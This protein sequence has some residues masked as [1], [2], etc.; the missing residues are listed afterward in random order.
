MDLVKS[1]TIAAQLE[2]FSRLPRSRQIGLIVGVAAIVAAAVLVLL[3]SQEPTYDTLYANLDDKDAGEVVDA[4]KNQGIDYKLDDKDGAIMVPAAKVHETRIKMAVLGLPRGGSA[5]F[6]ILDKNTSGFGVSQFMEKARYTRALEGE[7]ARSIMTIDGIH[8]ARVHLAIPKQTVFIREREKPTASVVVTLL[9][10]VNLDKKQVDAIV[11][12][13]ASSIPK[14]VPDAVTVVDQSGNLLSS[15]EKSPEMEL[16]DRQFSYT[17]RLEKSYVDR[18]EHILTPIVGPGGVRAQVVADVD[19]TVSEQTQELYNPDQAAVRSEQKQSEETV[20]KTDSGIPGALSNEPPGETQVPEKVQ[21]GNGQS[22]EQKIKSKKRSTIN[23]EVDR[24]ISHTRNP[25]GMVRR[26][27]VAV[28]VDDH[29]RT[30][31][32]GDSVNVPRSEEEMKRITSLVKEAVGFNLARGDSIN[33]VNSSFVE[34]APSVELAMWEQPWFWDI[35][36]QVIGAMVVLF[37][38]FII[39]RPIMRNLARVPE[40]ISEEEEELSELERQKARMQEE[41][42]REIQVADYETNLQTAKNLAKQDPKRVATVVRAWVL[43]A[44]AENM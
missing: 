5:G 23:Y 16:N 44:E 31:E 8:S 21:P 3:W 35:A 11:H 9:P 18:I 14:L 32:K 25:T 12:L 7:L 42:E 17:R 10:G 40:P 28:V 4:L 33:V 19:F 2:G 1:A 15:K 36:K 22:K 26:L 41:L 6:E 30:D 34:Q 39:L 13:V 24:T 27:S 29:Q 38:V 37:L 43:G 20:G